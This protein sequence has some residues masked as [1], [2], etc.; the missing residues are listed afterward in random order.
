[1]VWAFIF[2][3][4]RVPPPSGTR[5]HFKELYLFVCRVPNKEALS[6]DIVLNKTKKFSLSLL[7]ARRQTLGKHFLKK[8][9]TF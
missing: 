3:V 6:K 8:F 1:M 4:S 9:I 5:K 7:S 2:T